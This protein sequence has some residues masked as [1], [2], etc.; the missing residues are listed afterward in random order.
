MQLQEETR[1]IVNMLGKF[2]ALTIDQIKKMFEGTKFN[3]K[4]MVSFLCNTRMIQFLD[5]NYA[6]LQNNPNYN[7][8][9]LYC[10]W[11]LLD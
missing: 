5:N 11:V 7:P 2:G 9:T 10:I 6:V 8:E 3:P 1:V 4:P